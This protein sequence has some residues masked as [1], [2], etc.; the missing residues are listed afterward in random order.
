VTTGPGTSDEQPDPVLQLLENLTR[1]GTVIAAFQSTHEKFHRYHAELLRLVPPAT[2]DERAHD[3]LV[4]TL[5]EYAKLFDEHHH[6]EDSY[7]FPAL[8]KAEPALIP[9]V[10]Q[11]VEQH[12]QLAAQLAVVLE[13]ARGVQPGAAAQN[14]TVLLV[15]G[16]AEL[17]RVVDEHLLFEEAATVPVLRT[18]KSWPV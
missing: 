3:E 4:R 7:F 2:F 15:E 12:E 8:R 13:L 1:E 9:I 17:Q 14:H 11:L 16:L 5:D 18:W 10:G 6:A